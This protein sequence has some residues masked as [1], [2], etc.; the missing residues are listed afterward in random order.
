MNGARLLLWLDRIC[1]DIDAGR[2]LLPFAW[3]HV[4]VPLAVPVAVGVWGCTS[5]RD[6]APADGGPA[7]ISI[8]VTAP[9]Q[10][11][12]A[13]PRPDAGAQPDAGRVVAPQPRAPDAPAGSPP[14][15]RVQLEAP[16]IV[17]AE[18]T[19]VYGAAFEQAVVRRVVQSH[20]ESIQ[21]CRASSSDSTAEARVVVA[22]T[23][24]A[25]GAVSEASVVSSSVPAPALGQCVLD[26]V[27]RMR[28]PAPSGGGRLEV[29][30]PFVVRST[31]P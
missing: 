27:R 17:A 31:N 20:R 14:A 30:Y 2:P 12:A 1:R 5:V 16:R 25:T 8:V 15:D 22:F 13:A 11:E 19:V 7:P 3:R 26:V 23:I 28:F 29:T 9:G 18:A 24:E 10:P 6:E 21:R 4:L